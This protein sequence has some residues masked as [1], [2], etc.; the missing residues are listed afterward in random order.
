M[1]LQAKYVTERK[2][3]RLHMSEWVKT[4][5]SN[6]GVTHNTVNGC[7]PFR[8]ATIKAFVEQGLVMVSVTPVL[9]M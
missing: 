7:I 4:D 2:L 8:C 6:I 3:R 5:L 1:K 9:Y